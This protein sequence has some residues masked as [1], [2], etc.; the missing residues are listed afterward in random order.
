MKRLFGLLLAGCVAMPV[1]VLAFNWSPDTT[2]YLS[3]PS[4]I[5]KK[6]QLE[7]Q[8]VYSYS[9][10][11]T[12]GI[13]TSGVKSAEGSGTT[14]AVAEEL[15]YGVTDRLTVGLSGSWSATNG[16]YKY[17]NGYEET[18]QSY[19]LTNPEASLSYRL[20]EQG[21]NPVSVDS[22]IF[23]T[24][25]FRRDT[26]QREGGSFAVSREMVSL[27]LRGE[28]GLT[29]ND[30]YNGDAVIDAN[31]LYFGRVESQ[32]RF[33]KRWALNSGITFSQATSQSYQTNDHVTDYSYGVNIEPHVGVEYHL[34]ENR[35]VL[36]LN[37]A[38]GFIGDE[39]QSGY[40]N[41]T[42]ANRSMDTVSLHL[43]M[44]F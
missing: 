31:W 12:D 41:G 15:R 18:V 35:A 8:S 25:N 32:L 4:F 36:G 6:K 34:K 7:S 39:S 10:E 20:I 11:T 16:K 24:R 1:P 17:S 14:N 3:D 38:H 26:F 33:S 44:L 23:Y 5:P 9:R 21:K 22:R 28:A 27:T 40:N 13:N 37:Y 42:W 43:R 2:R 30:S 29:H 19:G